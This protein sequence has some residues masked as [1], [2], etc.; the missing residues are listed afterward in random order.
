MLVSGR[1]LVYL[2]SSYAS[3]PDC[4]HDNLW[5]SCFVAS[6]MNSSSFPPKEQWQNTR[7]VGSLKSWLFNDG[8]LI[9]TWFMKQY[10]HNW[11]FHPQHINTY[12]L[13]NQTGPFVFTVQMRWSMIPYPVNKGWSGSPPFISPTSWWLNQPNWKIWVN[14]GIFPRVSEWK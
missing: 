10:P 11:V 8:I 3:L 7:P 6:P 2:L 5:S 13:N 12:T 4:K 9:F 14:M 1:V